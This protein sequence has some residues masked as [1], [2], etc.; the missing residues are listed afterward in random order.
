MVDAKHVV[1]RPSLLLWVICA[2]L[3]FTTSSATLA[4]NE[5]DAAQTTANDEWNDDWGDDEEDDL[6]AGLQWTGFAE[7]AYGLRGDSEPQRS[8]LAEARVR[9]ETE[10]LQDAFT[11]GFK[12]DINADEVDE[13]VDLDLREL[14]LKFTLAEKLDIK[15][16]RQVLTWGTGDLL[17][18]NDLFPKDFVS[19]FAGRDDEYLKAPS[20]AVRLT[21]YGAAFNTDFVW[22][23][24]FESDNFLDGERFSFFVPAAGDI[25]APD[26]KLNPDE[27]SRSLNNGELA[28]RL[29]KRR[30][31]VEYALYAY[32]GFF[33]QPNAVNNA[34]VATFAPLN[35]YGLSARGPLSLGVFSSEFA[36]YDSRHDR[37]GDD[38]R[39]P[40]SQARLLL[41]YEQELVTNFTGGVQ[42]YT[43]WTQ[44]HGALRANSAMPDFEAERWRS[45]LTL[46][47]TYRTRRDT[48]NYSLFAFLSP[49]DEDY[50][51]RPNIEFRLSDAWNFSV[52]ANLFGGSDQHT[53][54][55][56]LEDNSNFYLRLRRYY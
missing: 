30:Q 1:L 32:R 47:L 5:E 40:N 53:F 10:W 13:R 27:P 12:G 56:Q 38:P 48:I 25:I 19:F 45:L 8:T 54:F 31:S 20:T 9:T 42:V 52:G 4:G 22:S 51:L 26:P 23:P 44:H 3:A 41:G 37:D 17:F 28:L 39:I 15:L 43:E 21:W 18:L 2:S 34:G 49:T 55:G 35:V 29:F 50:H 36:W 11:I 33:K 14:N 24:E 7:A 16:G 46:R 6:A